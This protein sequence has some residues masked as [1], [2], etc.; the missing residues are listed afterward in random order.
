MKAIHMTRPGGPEVLE[1]VDVPLPEITSSTGVRVKLHAAGINPVDTKM[2]SGAY[3][4]DPLPTILGCDGAGVVEST[5]TGVV[6]LREGDEVYFFHGGVSGIAGN[7]AEYIV[8]DQ[9]FVANKP[10]SLDF[11]QAAAAPLVLLTAW[12]SLF[13]RADVGAGDT[14]L[15]H[16]GAGGVGHVAVQLARHIGA[17]VITTVSSDAKADFVRDLGA[18]EVI[19]YKTQDVVET[20]LELTNGRGV[21]MV[22]DNVGGDVFRQ[23]FPAV[24]V[25]GDL[26]TLLLIPPDVDWSVARFRNLRISQ[27]VML[28]PLLL[29][30]EDAQRHQTW[31]L[32][33]CARLFDSS[34]LRIHVE[35]VY[36][37][38]HIAEAHR[39]IE[40]AST[41]GKLVLAIP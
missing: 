18:D 17:R 30:L 33:Q 31:I 11:N 40:T 35:R 41:R 2:R 36:P 37:F 20:T 3:P 13:D 9:R 19:N 24:R 1:V 29:G 10:A 6:E 21:D 15:I 22:M 7:Y 38:D 5:G 14:V 16:A 12:E 32:D 25:Y 27:E 28:S 39:A 4:V 8:L 34:K 23:S 26:V